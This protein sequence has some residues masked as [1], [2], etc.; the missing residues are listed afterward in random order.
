MTAKAFEDFNEKF[1]S[2]IKKVSRE[3]NMPL[4]YKSNGVSRKCRMGVILKLSF[5]E[6]VITGLLNSFNYWCRI[7]L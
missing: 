7:I 4:F 5:Y 2:D 3:K 1:K 6:M